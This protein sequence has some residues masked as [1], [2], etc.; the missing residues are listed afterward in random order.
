MTPLIMK[1]LGRDPLQYYTLR[2]LEH[3]RRTLR[4]NLARL[5]K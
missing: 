1:D 2:R 5:H 3:L 4:H